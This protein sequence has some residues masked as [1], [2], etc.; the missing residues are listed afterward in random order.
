MYIRTYAHVHMYS[1][2][3]CV[4]C[5]IVC[6]CAPRMYISSV[7]QCNVCMENIAMYLMLNNITYVYIS[8]LPFIDGVATLGVGIGGGHEPEVIVP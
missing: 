3:T 2:L 6:M 1:I 4:Q 8:S 5:L 7:I